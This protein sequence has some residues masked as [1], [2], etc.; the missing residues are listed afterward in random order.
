MSEWLS[1]RFLA[2]PLRNP[3]SAA[4]ESQMISRTAEYALRAVVHLAENRGEPCTLRSMAEKTDLPRDY[5][6]KVM[7]RLARSGLVLSQRGLHGG[8][9]LIGDAD[10]LSALDVINAVDPLRRS[11]DSTRADAMRGLRRSPLHRF[12]GGL[13]DHVERRFRETTIAD[14][15][16]PKRSERKARRG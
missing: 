15:T 7:Q 8:F 9:T 13:S 2:G 14:L 5:L 12:L 1:T 11:S 10:K 3:L 16:R 6:G 4:A